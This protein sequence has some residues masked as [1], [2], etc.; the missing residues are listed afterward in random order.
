MTYTYS[1]QTQSHQAKSVG[2][3]MTVS[4]KHCI[5]V[6]RHLRGKKVQLAQQILKKVMAVKQAIPYTKYHFDLGHKA[7]MGPGRYPVSTC[8]AIL[9]VLNNAEANAQT[10]GL[11]TS[12]LVIS[13]IIAQVGPTVWKYGRQ[14]RRQAKR[15]HLEILVEEQKK[16][17]N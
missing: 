12:D 10:K 8:K 2:L 1:K 9:G 16:S 3:S 15:T 17:V 14:G 7:G 4:T 6:C 11:R 5:E 13:H